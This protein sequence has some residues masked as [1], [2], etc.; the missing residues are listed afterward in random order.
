MRNRMSF[1]AAALAVAAISPSSALAHAEVTGRTPAPNSSLTSVK[2]VRLTFSEGVVTGKLSLTRAGKPAGKGMLVSHNKALSATFS[3][4]L[5][6]GTYTVN[7]SSLSD[8]G[9]RQSGSWTF[10]VR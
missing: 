10:T 8:D 3:K 1:I 5:A 6:K 4:K 2:S 9:H 7:W